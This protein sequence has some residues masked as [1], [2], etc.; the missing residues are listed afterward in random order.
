MTLDDFATLVDAF[1]RHARPG[2]N[3]YLWC[4]TRARLEQTIGTADVSVVSMLDLC[5]LPAKTGVQE[6]RRALEVSIAQWLQ[7]LAKRNPVR[8]IAVIDGLALGAFYRVGLGPIYRH[9]ANDRR[10]TVLCVPP[11]PGLTQILPQ[12]LQYE[13]LEVQQFYRKLLPVDHIVEVMGDGAS[14]S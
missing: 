1:Q 13:P 8:S 14:T 2:R 4:D 10:M 7:Q 9:H 5:S 12:P 6:V 3:L 11:S